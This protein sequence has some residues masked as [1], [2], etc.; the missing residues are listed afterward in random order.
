MATR[1]K[2]GIKDLLKSAQSKV[3]NSNNH[4][5]E[6][7]ATT[8]N[9]EK[10]DKAP[11]KTTAAKKTAKSKEPDGLDKLLKDLS[12]VSQ[13]TSAQSDALR[14]K[15]IDDADL[16]RYLKST[17]Q[18]V[19]E[20]SQVRSGKTNIYKLDRKLVDMFES[21]DL[22]DEYKIH[23]N[24]KTITT[25]STGNSLKDVLKGMFDDN[26]C[27]TKEVLATFTKFIVKQQQLTTDKKGGREGFQYYLIKVPDS[28]KE[29]REVVE[30]YNKSLEKTKKSPLDPEGMSSSDLKMIFTKFLDDE[31]IDDAATAED[32]DNDLAVLT[33]AL[34]HY[35]Q[36]SK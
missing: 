29:V 9:H 20:A 27:T 18:A 1:D 25:E 8:Q 15:M 2:K 11:K 4:K 36:K 7:H 14:K 5:E 13:M 23:K 31:A 3:N 30:D 28:W 35:D 32:V 34:K 12:L 16:H 33:V 24:G 17:A 26:P 10:V 22:G 19:R 6:K 21:L